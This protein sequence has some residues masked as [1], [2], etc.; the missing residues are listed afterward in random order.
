MDVEKSVLGIE[1]L[2]DETASQ[3]LIS[4][5]I[6]LPDGRSA[7]EVLL[8]GAR[9]SVEEAVSLAGQIRV[10]GQLE[11]TV[12]CE[13]PDGD[14]FGFTASSTFT[15]RVEMPKAREDMRADA[16]AQV[17]ECTVRPDGARLLLSAVAELTCRTSAPMDAPVVTA[18]TGSG[19]EARTCLLPVGRRV[20]LGESTLRI[21]ES[22]D[23]PDVREVLLSVG[24]VSMGEIAY[25]GSEAS[26]SGTLYLTVLVQKEGGQLEA[27]PLTVPFTEVMDAAYSAGPEAEGQLLQLSVTAADAGFSLLDAEAVIR[28]RLYGAEARELSVLADAYDEKCSFS[29]ER[30]QLR[31]LRYLGGTGSRTAQHESVLIPKHLP[32]AYQALAALITPVLVDTNA[33]NGRLYADAMLLT[34]VVYRCDGGFLH[35]FSEDIPV[36]FPLGAPESGLSRVQLLVLSATVTG[37]GR[38]LELHAE[39]G[40]RTEQYTE[41]TATLVTD[42]VAGGTPPP[43]RG[44]L[45]YCA[46][47]GETVWDV[48]KRF[49][50]PVEKVR[51]WNRDLPDPMPD[52]QAVV[53]IK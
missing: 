15:H 12:L 8:S 22:I 38:T 14:A 52:G 18:I 21:R 5:E 46:D 44:I 37:S 20:L 29:L 43:Y 35:A 1:I 31:Y 45:I 9:I 39:L 41:E 53:L 2:A 16:S 47:A 23:A 30:Q 49:A 51:A 28:I 36:R 33:E 11:I 27:K 13:D 10:S 24:G 7:K 34:S 3:T 4:S 42:A 19:V 6:P 25:A 40:A 17:L 48:G 50:V 32:E 26:V